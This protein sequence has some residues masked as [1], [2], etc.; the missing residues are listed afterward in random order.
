MPPKP[1]PGV[2]KLS[3]QARE[4][5][6]RRNKLPWDKQRK[7]NHRKSLIEANN[8][9][10]VREK[11]R[12]IGLENWSDPKIREKMILSHDLPNIDRDAK[13]VEL[14]NRGL[15]WPEIG[16][17]FN[18]KPNTARVAA[19][20]HRKRIEKMLSDPSLDSDVKLSR[21]LPSNYFRMQ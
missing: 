19:Q 11:K 12:I 20:R 2:T 18:I 9:P 21:I 1:G 10:E 16:K 6:I 17:L 5:L 3:P 13:L 15:S 4:D 8:R 7:I 14:N